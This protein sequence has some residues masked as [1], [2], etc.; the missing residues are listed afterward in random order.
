MAVK[1]QI[2]LEGTQSLISPSSPLYGP[3]SL[4]GLGAAHILGLMLSLL[5]LV[6]AYIRPKAKHPS[7]CPN[8]TQ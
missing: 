6:S 4:C 2:W 1:G 7:C 3:Q 8:S 5:G